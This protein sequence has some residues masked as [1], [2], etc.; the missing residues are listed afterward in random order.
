VVTCYR[1]ES[2]RQQY[3]KADTLEAGRGY[4]AM[5]DMRD[6]LTSRPAVASSFTMNITRPGWVLLGSRA[7]PIPLS[8]VSVVPADALAGLA[9]RYD[10]SARI[11]V[12]TDTLVSGEGHWLY[13]TKPCTIRLDP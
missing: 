10:P 5:L 6:T 12:E 4:W 1:F 9:N 8:E 11:Y 2:D 3:V 7:R 13:V